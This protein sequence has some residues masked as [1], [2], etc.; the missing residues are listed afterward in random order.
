MSVVAAFL[1]RDGHRAEA[2]SLAR[3][4][5]CA[6][7][8]SEF[9]WIGLLEPNEEELRTLQENFGLH[10]LAVEDAL[11][12][13][14]L[15]K[16][17]IYG[18]QLFVVARTA[19]LDGDIIVYGETAIFVGPT[20]VITVRHG[21]E[22]AHTELRAQLEAA[23]IML[24][25][26]VDYVLHAILD[27]IVDGYLPVVVTIEDEVLRM[28]QQALDA[29]LG[30]HEVTR[31][32]TLR[33]ELIKFQRILGPTSEL[34]GKLVHLNLPCLDPDV[35][36]YFNDVLDHVRRV[37]T[38]VGGLRDVLTSVF[39]IAMLLEQQ[40]QGM[41]TRQ[42]AAWA[43]ILAVPTAIA[44]IYGMNFENMPELRT[45]YGYFAVIGVIAA[46]CILLYARFRR[47]RWL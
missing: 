42:L 13:H 22:R 10:P 43:A 36:P 6:S 35:R 3:P 39:E 37:Q 18:D 40:R 20:H 25:N 21:S 9:V 11:K 34:V 41:I 19:H 24:R 8:R 2:V 14:Q 12:A 1:Y 17:D 26:G 23:P 16:A 38:M 44:G 5:R 28:E 27:F 31:L 46:L 45:H 4:L 7:D 32:F 30:R 47:M 33:R 29:F 15:P